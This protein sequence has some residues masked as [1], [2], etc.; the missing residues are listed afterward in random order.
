[1]RRSAAAACRCSQ[2]LRHRQASGTLT[3]TARQARVLRSRSARMVRSGVLSTSGGLSIVGLGYSTRGGRR[4]D[5]FSWQHNNFSAVKN[6]EDSTVETAFSRLAARFVEMQL[7]G[8]CTLQVFWS[9]SSF[10]RRLR[11]GR[12]ERPAAAVGRRELRARHGDGH[13][14]EGVQLSLPRLEEHRAAGAED[15]P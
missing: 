2:A 12:R 14:G 8:C 10:A 4:E 11:N 6:A 5:A 3:S 9:L 15:Q 1:M 13:H 7:E